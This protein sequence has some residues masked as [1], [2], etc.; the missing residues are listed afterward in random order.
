MWKDVL[1]TMLMVTTAVTKRNRSH[2]NFTD[3]LNSS[4]VVHIVC[5]RLSLLTM[6][7]ITSV[8]GGYRCS[9]ESVNFT[10][11]PLEADA[12]LKLQVIGV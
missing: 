10:D 4:V 3:P 6:L 7:L 11:E 2:L 5:E 1:L 12:C 8:P 9:I